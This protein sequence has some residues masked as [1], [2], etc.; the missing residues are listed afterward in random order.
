MKAQDLLEHHAPAWHEATRHP[1]LDAMRDGALTQ[2]AFATWL[3]QD[4]LFVRDIL[5][6][7]ARLLTQA[8][9]AD[10]AVLPRGLV[11]IEAELGWFEEQ[12]ERRSLDLQAPRHPTGAAYRDFLLRFL[13]H[14][15]YPAAITA[16][17][18]LER[19]YLEAWSGAVSGHPE[20]REFVE[21]WTTPDFAEYVAGLEQPADRALGPGGE[22]EQ[23][24][25]AF[26]D[27]ARLERDFWEMALSGGKR[28]P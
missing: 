9:R 3:A 28:W 26:L 16:L 1:F 25:A 10:Q 8:L 12:A 5:D 21:H 14:E 18:A 11:A 27:V 15:P 24:E 22:R 20:Y 13:E 6:C 23:V 19:A 2:E 7:Q 17:W 4:Y